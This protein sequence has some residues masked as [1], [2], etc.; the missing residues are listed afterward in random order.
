MGWLSAMGKYYSTPYTRP[1]L[2]Q[3]CFGPA[4]NNYDV[5]MAPF[6]K[7]GRPGRTGYRP[8]ALIYGV[9]E[10]RVMRGFGHYLEQ[11]HVAAL[12]RIGAALARSM[13]YC[14]FAIQAVVELERPARWQDAA[15]YHSRPLAAKY[16]SPDEHVCFWK[17]GLHAIFKHDRAQRRNVNNAR[18]SSTLERWY[19]FA[20][21]IG[22]GYGSASQRDSYSN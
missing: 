21:V 3:S 14:K 9:D 20:V 19:G 11:P 13:L 1:S 10:R 4:P 12:T 6:A 8:R 2:K 7:H 5:C 18:S 15:R 17:R 22:H 16:Y